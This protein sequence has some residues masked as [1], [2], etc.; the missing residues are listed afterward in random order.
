M[1]PTVQ[2]SEPWLYFYRELQLA[3]SSHSGTLRARQGLGPS[4]GLVIGLYQ[5]L[6]HDVDLDHDLD[7]ELHL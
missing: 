3:S 7:L 6:D 1:K 2:P 4:H 5:D